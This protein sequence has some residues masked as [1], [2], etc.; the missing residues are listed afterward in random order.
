MIYIIQTDFK[1]I[2]G[3]K[4]KIYISTLFFMRNITL[5]MKRKSQVPKDVNNGH[6]QVLKLLIS[7]REVKGKEFKLS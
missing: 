3:K 6:N 1:I 7:R 2:G 5:W 4:Y